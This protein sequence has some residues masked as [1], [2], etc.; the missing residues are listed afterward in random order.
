MIQ[1][2]EIGNTAGKGVFIHAAVH[3]NIQ[4]K[5]LAFGIGLF[6]CHTEGNDSRFCYT[7]RGNH[8]FLD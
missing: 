2:E 5:K 1:K 6:L 7:Q 3:S 4:V 8:V